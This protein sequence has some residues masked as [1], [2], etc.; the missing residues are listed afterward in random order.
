M[1]LQKFL[2]QP[3][4]PYHLDRMNIFENFVSFKMAQ[5]HSG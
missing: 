2:M 5:T 3:P 4:K 1:N